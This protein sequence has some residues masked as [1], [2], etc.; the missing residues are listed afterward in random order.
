MLKCIMG[1]MLR[2]YRCLCIDLCTYK[3]VHTQSKCLCFSAAPSSPPPS[4]E[5]VDVST[6]SFRVA[7][8][9]PPVHTHNGILR[10]GLLNATEVETGRVILHE[11]TLHLVTLGNLHPFYT[12]HL[13][14]AAVTVSAGPPTQPIT[15]ITLQTGA[16]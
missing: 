8:T 13:T 7:W 10:K 15:I 2:A 1:V 3:H 11:T 4:L 5:L 6:H 9:P 14:V 16:L 12:Y